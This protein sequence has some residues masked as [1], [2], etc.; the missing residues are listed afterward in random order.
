[1][2]EQLLQLPSGQRPFG[3]LEGKRLGVLGVGECQRRQDSASGPS[4]QMTASDSI[5]DLIGKGTKHCLFLAL[6]HSSF[7]QYR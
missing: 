2:T 7:E 6:W 3:E 4:G 1:M 5:Q